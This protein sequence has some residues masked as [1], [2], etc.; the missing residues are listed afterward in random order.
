MSDFEL[1]LTVAES[2]EFDDEER[3][4][5]TRLLKR[6]L[7]E[8]GAPVDL[9][10]TEA[11]PHTRSGEA[12]VIGQLI[13]Q[14]GPILL[15]PF[16]EVIKAWLARQ[17]TVPLKMKLKRGRKSIDIEYDPK[18]MKQADLEKLIANAMETLK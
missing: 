7:D 12:V 3:D 4:R 2:K 18:R 16:V 6:E 17:Q 5:L 9:A 13:T 14:F 10:K 8:L 1:E 11:P 15:P